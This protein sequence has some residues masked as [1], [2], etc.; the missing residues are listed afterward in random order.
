[1]S[2]DD[3]HGDIESHDQALGAEQRDCMQPAADPAAR[4]AR[5]CGLGTG[6][7]S[8]PGGMGHLVASDCQLG[9]THPR[10][11]DTSVSTPT[12]SALR[13]DALTFEGLK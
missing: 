9:L 5:Y 7:D 13:S 8:A 3:V 4:R 6:G 1:M 12:M 2:I 10:A 11:F